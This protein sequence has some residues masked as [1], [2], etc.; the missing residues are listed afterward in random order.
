MCIIDMLNTF[1]L[2]VYS[3]VVGVGGS[4]PQLGLYTQADKWSKMG[5][6]A[7]SQTMT[8]SFV[9][10]LAKVQDE[11]ATFRRYVERINRFTAFITFPSL[12][13]FAVLGAPLF[14]LLFGNKWDDA[15]PLFQILALR[16]VPIV[17]VSVM[18]NYL[19]ALGYARS[20]FA[21]EVIKDSLTVIAILATVWEK[22]LTLLVWGQFWASALTW[23][24]V[25]FLVGRKTGWSLGF[26]T[27]GNLP[28][29]GAVAVAAVGGMLVVG[30]V[31][32][33]M[34]DPAWSVP[35]LFPG[36]FSPH[37]RGLA[38]LVGGGV[39]GG[40]LYLLTLRLAG[41]REPSE[42][43]GYLRKKRKKGV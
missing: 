10:L 22:D 43:L 17:L 31:P 37:L 42:A 1:F 11:S 8:S 41:C 23:L 14:H 38:G 16:G 9:P 25:L 27:R 4:V 13:G 7:L 12:V 5:S 20:L 19:L 29:L 26:M 35:S 21:V 6:A 28:F 24:L 18:T 36:P 30:A 34:G 32:F 3:F 2:N 40:V 15:I 39:A 33:I